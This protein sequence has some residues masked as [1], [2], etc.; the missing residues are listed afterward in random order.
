ML[1]P[2]KETNVPFQNPKKSRLTAVKKTVGIKAKTEMMIFN[3][4]L[5]K[6]AKSPYCT[7]KE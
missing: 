7:N 3:K 6:K 1:S 2:I 4:I 5:K